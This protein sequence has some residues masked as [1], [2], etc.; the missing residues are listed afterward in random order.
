MK[1]SIFKASILVEALPYIKEF[2]GQIVVIKYGGSAMED[3][4][5]KE[6]VLT[7]IALMKYVGIRPVIVHGGGKEIT[8]LAK[9]LGKDSVFLDGFRVTDKEMMNATEMVLSGS[10]NKDIVSRLNQN[11]VRAVGIS[12]RDAKLVKAVQKSEKYGFVGEVTDVDAQLIYDLEDSGYV[13][14]V[15]PV[16]EDEKGNAFNVNAD[17]VA[18]E[19]ARKLKA[20]KLV[21]LTDVD[22]IFRDIKKPETLISSLNVKEAIRLIE[23]KIIVSGMLP[24]IRSCMDAILGGVEKI[25]IINGTLP[26]ALLLEIFTKA[27][28][29]TQIV[30]D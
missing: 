25:H 8:G 15:S 6:K 14:V 19:I 21:L 18:S 17:I 29:G 30:R 11:G 20:K 9:N 3:E 23:E 4:N 12:G 27:G 22:G 16:A 2:S 10:V 13:P 1:D 28:I 24:K 5:L 7:D 26:H